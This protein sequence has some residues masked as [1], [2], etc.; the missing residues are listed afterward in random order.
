MSPIV[1]E[2]K[3]KVRDAL[4]SARENFNGTDH[5]FSI[6]NKISP[7]YFNQIK[8]GKLNIGM[9]D[10]KWIFQAINL[11]VDTHT[12]Q[13]NTARTAVFNQ[14]EEEVAF[15]QTHSKSMIFVDDCGIGKTYTAKY[16]SRKNR[17][18]F[19]IDASQAKTQFQFVK[20]LA[21]TI[22]L[23]PT[24][25]KANIKENIKFYLKVL[26]KPVI[27]IDEAGDLDYNALLDLKEFWNA[28]E[29]VCGWY[30]MGADGLKAKFEHGI[31]SRKVCFRELFSRFNN[32]YSSSTPVGTQDKEAFMMKLTGDVLDVNMKDK[33][34]INKIIRQCMTA[35][36]G[37]SIGGLRRAESILALIDNDEEQN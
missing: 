6:K 16:L 35:D 14:I 8:N 25:K 22:G 10:E 5:A 31:S 20:M 9:A 21:Q 26:G 27:I 33:T 37:S 12:R 19:Y 2:L 17:N 24:G 1:N 15:C 28:T 29:G 11:G 30:M 36:A 18:C 34:K 23:D 32:R 3:V 7:S 4:M 13:W